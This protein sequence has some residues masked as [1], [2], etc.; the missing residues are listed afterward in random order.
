MQAEK[1]ARMANQIA[2]AFAH[3]PAARAAERVAGHIRD[4]WDPRM[5]AGLARIAAEQPEILSPTVV[6]AS[7]QLETAAG[8]GPSPQ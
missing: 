6:E 8:T 3:L 4:F 1:L 2:T 5:R 7:R